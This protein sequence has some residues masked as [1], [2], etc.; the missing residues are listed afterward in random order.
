LNNKAKIDCML[1]TIQGGLSAILGSSTAPDQ[2]QELTLRA[3][4]FYL[5]R[6]KGTPIDFDAYKTYFTS[7]TPPPTASVAPTP[8]VHTIPAEPQTQTILP[9]KEAPYPQT[10]AEI[11]ALITSGAPIPGIKEIPNTVLTNKATP[12]VEKK[13][14]K[15]WEKDVPEEMVQGAGYV[16]DG[17]KRIEGT[18]GD[19]RDEYIVQ[20]FPEGV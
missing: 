17:E 15:P 16:L 10:F 11:V 1:T 5:S 14:R 7:K 12:A 3:Q 20:E 4:C 19:R 2:I 9:T 13:R 6:K 18:F 8:P